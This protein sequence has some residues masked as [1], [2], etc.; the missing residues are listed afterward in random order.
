MAHLEKLEI[1]SFHHYKKEN[2]DVLFHLVHSGRPD[3]IDGNFP[4]SKGSKV[5]ET[6]MVWEVPCFYLSAVAICLTVRLITIMF[7]FSVRVC[8]WWGA[9]LPGT[10]THSGFYLSSLL[11]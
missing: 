10:C 1:R 3:E 8:I 9:I 7:I 5:L 6:K 11:F 4:S 2:G